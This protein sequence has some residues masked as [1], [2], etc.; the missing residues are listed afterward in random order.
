MVSVFVGQRLQNGAD[1]LAWTAPGGK[2]VNNDQF[3]ASLNELSFEI[4]LWMRE[5]KDLILFLSASYAGKK[6]HLEEIIQI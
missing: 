5:T 4:S 2:E 6:L 1:D 3:G